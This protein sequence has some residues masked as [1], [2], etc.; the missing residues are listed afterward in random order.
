MAVPRN[1]QGSRRSAGRIRRAFDLFRRASI[2]AANLLH[3]LLWIV[4]CFKRGNRNKRGGGTGFSIGHT[5]DLTE[6]DELDGHGHPPSNNDLLTPAERR[7]FEQR[8][9]IDMKRLT[10]IS[11]KSHRDRIQEF[12][13]YLA[14][15][16]EHYD[17]P[18]VDP[19]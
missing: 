5:A 1:P 3:L 6:A 19:G 15:L 16:S 13:Q 7:Y 14:N 17:I 18:K 11:S 8:Q 12:N 4:G 10:K 2:V 9:K